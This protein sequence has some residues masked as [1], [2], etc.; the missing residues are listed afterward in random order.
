MS[1]I[2]RKF[3]TDLFDVFSNFSLIQ[4]EGVKEVEC[5][6]VIQNIYISL[7]LLVRMLLE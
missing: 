2:V 6:Y 5:F 3:M 7:T 1:W 4:K